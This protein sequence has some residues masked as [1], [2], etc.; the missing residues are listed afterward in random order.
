MKR[1]M[2]VMRKRNMEMKERINIITKV[3]IKR[4]SERKRM[5]IKEG[6]RAIKDKYRRRCEKKEIQERER[7]M[8]IN[9]KRMERGKM[10]HKLKRKPQPL[11]KFLRLTTGGKGVP[12]G[13]KRIPLRFEI[14]PYIHCSKFTI[15]T[16][17]HSTIWICLPS[18]YFN[19]QLV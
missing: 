2:K 12:Q 13:K 8:N 7:T 17:H 18:H 15:S 1:R 6:E 4:E 14:S 10:R 11:T 5:G 16:S 19:I 3:V 9:W